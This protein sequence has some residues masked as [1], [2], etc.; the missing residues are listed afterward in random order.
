VGRKRVG[1]GEDERLTALAL[2]SFDHGLQ[3]KGICKRILRSVETGERLHLAIEI[4]G[5]RDGVAP[6]PKGERGEAA[7]RIRAEAELGGDRHRA[8]H[9]GD[10]ELTEGEPVADVRP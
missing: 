3:G 4:E 9:M 8:Q 1:H 10:V 7:V 6:A 2:P 5:Q